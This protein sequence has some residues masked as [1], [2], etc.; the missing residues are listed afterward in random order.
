M[1]LLAPGYLSAVIFWGCDRLVSE[2]GYGELAGKGLALP[3]PVLPALLSP[4]YSADSE[5]IEDN[6]QEADLEDDLEE[7]PSEEEEELPAPTASTP[8]IPDLI[9]PSKDEEEE[10]EPF[11]EDEFALTPPSP[12][13]PPIIPFSQTRLCRAQKSVRPQ[14]PLPSSIA[15]FVDE[16]L[17]AP[18]PPSPPPSPLS[19][20]SSPLPRIPSPPLPSSPTRSDSIPKADLQPRKIARLS[21]LPFRF[22]IRESFAD[23]QDDKEVLRAQLASSE[24][25]AR[26]LRS[27]VVTLEQEAAYARDA[28]SLAM[29]RIRTLQHQRQESNDRLTR[30]EERVRALERQDGPPVTSN[31]GVNQTALDQLVT[32]RVADALAAMEVNRSTNQEET[33]RTTATTRTCSYKEFRSCMHGNFSRTEGAVGLTRWFEK[34]ESFFQVSKVKDGDRVKYVVCTMLDGALTWWNSYVRSVGID[35]ANATPWSEFKQMLIKKYYPRSENIKGNVTSSKPTDI[36]ETI[37]MAQSLMDQVIQDLGEKTVDN[38]RKWEGN[39]N[40]NN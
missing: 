8:I 7:E 31:S 33:N 5:P 17:A 26:Y 39:H 40:N 28:W 19:P 3:A 25:E 9:S 11:E 4:D 20:L 37:T 27:R 16:W 18:A 29:D 13:S 1:K 10:T 32:Q 23:A 38:K 12:I 36:H 35:A 22:E 2:P 34:L 21:P 30:F 14:T 6:P 24:R 15:A